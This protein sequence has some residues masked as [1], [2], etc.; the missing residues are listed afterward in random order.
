MRILLIAHDFPPNPSPQSLRWHYLTR[1]L[2]ALGVEVHVLTA[3]DGHRVGWLHAPE[4]ARVHRV[5]AGGVG[6]L[7]GA[8]R[9][10][11]RKTVADPAT[12]VKTA[13]EAMQCG[14]QASSAEAPVLNWKGKLVALADRLHAQLTFPDQRGSWERPARKRL[15]VLLETVKPDIV[16]CSHEP[17]TSLR[18]GLAAKSKG[19]RWAADLGD[20]VLSFYT[21]RRWRRASLRLER[22]TCLQA[23]HVTVTTEHARQLMMQRHGVPESRVT[24]ITQGFDPAA[25]VFEGGV[26]A[27][28]FSPDLLE[29]LYTGSFYDFR[30]PRALVEGV[31][32][33][34]GARLSIATQRVPEWLSP[35]IEAHPDRLRLL[36]F[37]PHDVVRALQRAA[38]VLV[39]IANDDPAH[40]P[41]KVYEYLGAGRPILHVG[42][43][44]D[45]IAADMLQ[46]HRRGLVCGNEPGQ[47]ADAIARLASIK[48]SGCLA[49]SFALDAEVVSGYQWDALA[50]RMHEVLLQVIKGPVT[51][52]SVMRGK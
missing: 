9:T 4:G 23:D 24:V 13:E 51:E 38:D 25:T 44:N 48:Q 10:W 31:L 1:E 20:P 5:P 11:R 19:F 41:G 46:Q 50:R 27:D 6:A 52:D 15:A 7:V 33:I 47:V 43:R 18:L 22:Q 40:V 36:G 45:D 2:L 3:R 28:M 8:I 21:P 30:Q 39:N 37:L 35:L 29:L 26:V 17:A 49:G 32:T 34:P 16:V 42:D 12:K 14:L